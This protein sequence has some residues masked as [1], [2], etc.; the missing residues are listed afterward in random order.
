MTTEEQFVRECEALA[1]DFGRLLEG[2]PIDSAIAALTDCLAFS[3]AALADSREKADEVLGEVVEDLTEA[4]D[5][6]W[7]IQGEGKKA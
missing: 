4:L 2:K 7:R 3:I 1:Q 6:H 5:A